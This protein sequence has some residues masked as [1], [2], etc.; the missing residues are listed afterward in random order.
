MSPRAL[1]DLREPEQRS[2]GGAAG[3]RDEEALTRLVRSLQLR[4]LEHRAVEAFGGIGVPGRRGDA[5]ELDA[6]VGRDPGRVGRLGG[7]KRL[8]LELLGLVQVAA[9]ERARAECGERER[10]VVAEPDAR[11]ELERAPVCLHRGRAV[12][13]PLRHPRLEQQPRDAE[14]VVP[15]RVRV[16]EDRRRHGGDRGDVPGARRASRADEAARRGAPVV[17]CRLERR[18]RV[19]RHRVGPLLV[20]GLREREREGQL[21]EPELLRRRRRAASVSA[22][23][24]ASSAASR[25]SSSVAR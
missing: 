12:L 23:S 9:R 22:R 19:S 16:A 15:D 5:R 18:A 21:R 25:S 10:R 1:G 14:R 11:R 20:A 8:P 7:R 24:P 6:C 2:R 4:P 3:E 13:P 17:P